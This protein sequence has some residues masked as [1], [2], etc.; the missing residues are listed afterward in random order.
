M[1]IS[2]HFRVEMFLK[3]IIFD[4]NDQFM[5][6]LTINGQVIKT[7][8]LVI[9]LTL[10]QVFWSKMI[11]NDHFYKW[12]KIDHFRSKNRCSRLVSRN[13]TSVEN[14]RFSYKFIGFPRSGSVRSK[15]LK[16]SQDL[17]D[18]AP[19]LKT[20]GL[21]PNTAGVSARSTTWRRVWSFIDHFDHFWSNWSFLIKSAILV[22]GRSFWP[23]WSLVIWSDHIGAYA[24]L[25]AAGPASWANR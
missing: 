11:K 2:V 12:S 5:I 9:Y 21:G 10:C 6:I 24:A 23:I 19:G 20:W 4:Q 15:D 13:S 7:T 8:I 22:E 16:R 14:H 18:P 1:N 3:L 25:W 17:I